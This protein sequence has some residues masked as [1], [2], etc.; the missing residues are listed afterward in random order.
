MRISVSNPF[1][2]TRCFGFFIINQLV[3]AFPCSNEKHKANKLTVPTH[4]K[5]TEG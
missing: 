2:N 5:S 3:V 1:N 4:Y